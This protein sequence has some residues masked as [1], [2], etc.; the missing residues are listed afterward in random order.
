MTIPSHGTA[1]NTLLG[2]QTEYPVRYAP[3]VLFPIP[4]QE[5]RAAL[6][7]VVDPLPFQGVDIWTHYEVSWLDAAGKPLIAVAEIRV[8][9]TSPFLIESKSLKLY[10]NSLNFERFSSQADFVRRVEED[11]SRVAAATVQIRLVLP[12]DPA[13]LRMGQLPGTCLDALPLSCAEFVLDA[14]HLH[15]DPERIVSETI[16]TQLLRSLCPITHQPDWGSVMLQYKG[17]AID[18][19]GFLAYIVS[20]RNHPDFHEQCVE[21][22]FMDILRQCQPTELTVYAR[23]T[24]RGGLDINP[25]RSNVASQPLDVRLFRQ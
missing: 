9:A 17:P 14:S 24:R 10:F 7:L 5:G 16:N 19:A 18:H 4:R 8:P 23:Y 25:F 11:L 12:D 1:T 6:G 21:R 2:Q 13:A 3:E 15:A 22:I 20:F